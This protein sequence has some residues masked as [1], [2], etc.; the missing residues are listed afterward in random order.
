MG[1]KIA[2]ILGAGASY[3]V[4]PNN[5]RNQAVKNSDFAPPRTKDLFTL[6]R[7]LEPYL[8]QYNRAYTAIGNMRNRLERAEE[9]LEGLLRQLKESG[10][11]SKVQ[12]F[13][14]IPLYLQHIFGLISREYCY[15]PLN[16]ASLISEAVRSDIEQV[17]FVTM[18]YDLFIDQALSREFNMGFTDMNKYINN[19]EKWIYVKLHGS[20]DWSRKIKPEAIKNHGGGIGAYLENI[21]SM[22][23]EKNLEKP[24]EKVDNY[25]D[26]MEGRSE[27]YPALT[28]PVDN[29][30]EFN[31]PDEHIQAL[32]SLLKECSSFL[33]IGVS[34]KDKDLLDLLKENVSSAHLVAVV[35]GA[36]VQETGY[37]FMEAVPA[38]NS[39]MTG[40][41]WR[42]FND[43]FSSFVHSK[44]LQSFFDDSK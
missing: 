44:D 12:Q 27:Y 14:Q 41:K 8:A 9:S 28:V 22:D 37:R 25:L 15:H 7:T 33:L 36:N 40:T 17:A 43:G 42:H 13:K 39:N 19:N 30:Y 31:C 34:G 24:I 29:K 35:G 5:Q 3:D 18:N 10:E 26:R 16:Y 38:F 21:D 6:S 2:I 32:K 11:T 20:V 1:K 4:I 23:I